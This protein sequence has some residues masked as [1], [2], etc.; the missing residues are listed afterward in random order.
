MRDYQ[1]ILSFGHEVAE[2]YD[3]TN[4]QGDESETVTFLSRLANGGP[5][6]ELAIGTGRIAVPLA[7]TGIHVDGIELSPAMADKLTAKPGA[8]GIAVSIGDFAA[9]DVPGS[10]KLIYVVY[11]TFFNLLT[12]DDQ[13]RC[14]GNVA[15]HLSS[16]GIFVIEAFDPA[17]L[18]GLRGNQYVDAEAIELDTVTLDVGRHDPVA[19]ILSESHVEL[20]RDGV[21]VFPIVCRYCW[22]SELD[23][24]ARLAG[25]RLHNRW[26]GWEG[27]PFTAASSRHVSVYGF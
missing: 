27:E 23:L 12:Q 6:L 13:V 3:A 14:F 2:D 10:Y 18:H 26:G 4:V 9:V 17:Y 25:L 5:A 21:K 20:S 22:P 19:Q 11:N 7:A 1:P 16:D 24:M 15:K 8:D